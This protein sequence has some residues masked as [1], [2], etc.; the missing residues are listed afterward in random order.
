MDR[1]VIE[2]S[3]RSVSCLR[4]LPIDERTQFPQRWSEIHSCDA[5]VPNSCPCATQFLVT[6]A[7]SFIHKALSFLVFSNYIRGTSA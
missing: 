2:V 4:S 5:L 1:Y 3:D 6:V 7:L